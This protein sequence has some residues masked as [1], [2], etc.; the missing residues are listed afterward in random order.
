MTKKHND[1]NKWEINAP[2]HGAFG[3]SAI[4]PKDGEMYCVAD[5]FGINDAEDKG[6]SLA[7]ANAYL[8]S[9]APDLLEAL[10][11]CKSV[12]VTILFD[13][14]D[15]TAKA[16]INRRIRTSS[17]AIAKATGKQK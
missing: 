7:L 4:D 14:Q 15:E 3:I 10:I 12:L 5:V 9:A 16:V 13:T 2:V 11:Q 6:C 1:R 8:I 17:Y